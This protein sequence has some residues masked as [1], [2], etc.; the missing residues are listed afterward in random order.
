MEKKENNSISN[1]HKLNKYNLSKASWFNILSYLDLKTFLNLEKSSK[2]FRLIFINYYSEKNTIQQEKEEL[3]NKNISQDEK[4]IIC[5]NNISIPDLF[6]SDIKR[7]K[8]NIIEKYYNFLIQIPYV[9]AEF[10]SINPNKT[11]TDLIKNKV[12]KINEFNTDINETLNNNSN[13]DYY[14]CYYTYKN[15]EFITNNKFMIFYNNTLNVYE[16]NTENIF[17]KKFSQF[18]YYQKI[19]FFGIIQNSIFLINDCGNL[20]IMNVTN[21]ATNLKRI[22]FYIP[23]EL[24]KIFYIGD[25]FIFLTKEE[26]FYYINFEEIFMKNKSDEELEPYQKELLLTHFPTEDK[27]IFK[28]FPKKINKNYNGI[29]DVNSNCNNYIMFIDKNY[30][31]YGLNISN[32]LKTDNDEGENKNKN[33]KNKSKNSSKN[34]SRKQSSNDNIHNQNEKEY[35]SFYKVCQGIKF[36]NYYTM[37]FGENYWILLE[38][39]YKEALI[40]WSTD[41]VTEWFER[42]LGF[43]DYLNVVKYQKVNGKDII[44]GDRKYFKD[45]LGMNVSKI[46]KLCN[47]EIKKVEDGSVNN[48]KVWGYGNNRNGQLGLTN[49]KYSKNPLKLETPENEMKTNNDFIVKIYCS[50]SISVLKTRRDKIYICG[51][52]NIKEKQ[53]ILNLQDDN[54]EKEINEL[55]KKKKG[56]KGNKGKGNHKKKSG[57][58][59]KMEKEEKEKNDKNIWVEISSDIKKMFVNNSYLKLKDIYIRNNI[60]YIFGLKLNKK[61][62]C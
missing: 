17:E 51:N 5:K 33:K 25:Y 47:K 38:Q 23:E 18:F 12:I 41:Q 40:D 44:D 13:L 3:K 62:F 34:S 53:N 7:Y 39:N 36:Q 14:D 31:L 43:E 22:R 42:E 48:I 16:I 19:I 60:L 11:L 56:N 58:D 15:C 26:S 27:S 9:L 35:I 50:N 54:S 21:Y 37:S 52:F 10:C 6:F 57:K 29:L 49:I 32:F 45:I 8:K 4:S 20:T 28:L 55:N 61:D 2:H 1:E 46:K 59:E 24:I 30:D